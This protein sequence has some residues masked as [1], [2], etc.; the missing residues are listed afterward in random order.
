MNEIRV[1]TVENEV[2]KMRFIKFPWEIYR[3]NPNWVPPLIYDVRKNLDE[4]KNPFYNHAKIKMFLALDGKTPVGRIA[5]I[6]NDHHNKKYND[7]VGFF[8][9]FEC[10]NSKIVSTALFD[11]ASVWLKEQGMDTVRGPVNLSINDEIGLLMNAYDKPPILLM[12]YNPEYY[13]KLITDYG[14]EKAKDLYAYYLDQDMC[15]ANQKAMDK[16]DR[17][18]ELVQKRE[19]IKIRKISLK[20]IEGELQ[21]V[22][23]VYNNAWV[24]NW[25]SVQMTSDEFK[26]VAA[27][28]KPL[29]DED[30]VYFAEVEGRPVGFSL[31][32]P[33]YN[34]IFK[35]M[36]GKL[37]PF[38]IFKILTGRKKI[39]GI[40]VI[41]M[42]VIPEYQRK[43][44]EAVFIRN[45]IKIG[46]S[47][48]Y[49]A[50][51]I[52]WV[53]EDNAPMVQT[54][55]N[56]GADLYKTFRIFDKKI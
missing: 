5:A 13:I 51:D 9:Y 6:V 34:Q 44:I 3:G 52:S 50:A 33:D 43:G 46:M 31:S 26:Y 41:M 29:V 25:G 32:M 24:D 55:V 37:F 7:K 4:K 8:G 1:I 28:L 54:A 10:I 16:L 11:A 22:M 39:T 12:I 20:D 15:A 21:K 45:T 19:N 18:S 27:S 38:G 42:G 48:G 35:T 14:F 23:E 53:L 30:I 49:H 2:D 40:R 56:L 17:V 47:K 36:N